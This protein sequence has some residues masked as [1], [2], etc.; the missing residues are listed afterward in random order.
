MMQS[1]ALLNP[2]LPVLFGFRCCGS[3]DADT[4]RQ[5]TKES[6]GLHASVVEV[7]GLVQECQSVRNMCGP[8]QPYRRGMAE[9]WLHGHGC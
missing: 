5:D 4:Q 6:L 9:L 3:G 8:D 2:S 7:F 1:D